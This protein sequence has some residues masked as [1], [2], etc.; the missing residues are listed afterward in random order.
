MSE[1]PGFMGQLLGVLYRPREIFSTVDEGDLTKG[2]VIAV[3]MVALAAYSTMTYMDKIPLEV[4][5]P[6]L[7]G[8]DAG[9]MA[10]SLGTISGIAAGVTMLV[11]WTFSGLI[12]HL[13]GKF[14]G[15]DGSMK[16]YFALYGFTTVPALLNQVLRVVD[17]SIMDSASLIGYFVSYRDM[18]SKVVKAFI[19]AN[20]FNVWSLAGI[21][22]VVLSLEENYKV[23]RGRALIIA[24][25]P[26]LALFA[27]NYF[28]G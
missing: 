10:G 2:V 15:G 1:K 3:L 18:S 6:Q 7:Q 14:S 22:L 19:G 25:V 26:S 24:L 17:A 23:G 8:V 13:L 27:L 28:T 16:R 12:L 20:L 21:A 11:G 9:P 4:I 5:T